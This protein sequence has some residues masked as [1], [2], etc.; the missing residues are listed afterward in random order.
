MPVLVNLM[1]FNLLKTF[2][3]QIVIQKKKFTKKSKSKKQ[4]KM[5]LIVGKMPGRNHNLLIRS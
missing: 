2:R 4:K 3:Y 1:A 5:S